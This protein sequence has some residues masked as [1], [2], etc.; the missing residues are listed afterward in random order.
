[1][2]ARRYNRPL[3][4]TFMK[5]ISREDSSNCNHLKLARREQPGKS[6]ILLNITVEASSYSAADHSWVVGD[7]WDRFVIELMTL[8]ERRQGR[9]VVEGASPDHSDWSSIQRIQQATWR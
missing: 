4:G 5:L 8:D 1:M 7:E 2:P 3:A 9:A 6:D